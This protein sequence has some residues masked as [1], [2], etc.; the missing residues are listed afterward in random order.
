MANA[1]GTWFYKRQAICGPP[2]SQSFCEV[3][4]EVKLAVIEIPP[5]PRKAGLFLAHTAKLLLLVPIRREQQQQNS[6]A[7]A[8]TSL[9]L[10]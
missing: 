6:R 8:G 2:A 9:E 3:D 10:A 5:F 1:G 4:V 7:V